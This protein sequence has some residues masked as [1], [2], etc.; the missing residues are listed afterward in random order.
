MTLTKRGKRFVALMVALFFIGCLVLAG[1]LYGRSIGVFGAS[2]PQAEVTVIIPRGA[3]AEEIG[4]L[5]ERENVIPSAFGFRI[6]LYLD[7]GFEEIQAGRYQLFTGLNARDAIA[8]LTKGALPE[9][10][11]TVT[12]PEGSWLTDFARVID[13]DTD[14]E[15]DDFLAIVA[16][17]QIRSS[18]LPK[19]VDT[20]E[21]LLFPSTYQVV[22]NDDARSIAQRLVDE[23]EA[24]ADTIGIDAAGDLDI[25]PYEAIIVASM[26]EAEA[27][28][29]EER[30]KIA[31]V[32][33][34]RLDEGMRLEI[35]AT[36]NYALGEHKNVL[37]ASDLKIDSPYN[38]RLYSGLPPTPIGAPGQASLEAVIEPAEG[39]WLFYVVADCE[40]HHAFSES[41]REFLNNKARYQQLDCS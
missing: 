8:T 14:I 30:A 22:E 2:N 37:T 9:E 1:Y 6:A 12:F 31:R 26:V 23:F 24:R 13:R 40:G 32:I 39:A 29:D 11:T 19:D 4:A 25:S 38:T 7:G 3:S 27:K 5:L 35:D 20:L 41:Y 33:Y 16:N 21:G 17:A 10:F 36:V 28:L 15:G 18:Y 34:N